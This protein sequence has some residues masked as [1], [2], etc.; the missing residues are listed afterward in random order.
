MTGLC[1][2]KNKAKHNLSASPTHHPQ[3]REAEPF[4]E[5]RN[6][7]HPLSFEVPLHKGN[8][9][10]WKLAEKQTRIFRVGCNLRSSQVLASTCQWALSE[11][12]GAVPEPFQRGPKRKRRETYSPFLVLAKAS[13]LMFRACGISPSVL[14]ICSR[15]KI[16][17]FFESCPT[18]SYAHWST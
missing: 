9:M 12:N 14:W 17:A 2:K 1:Y 13:W 16:K 7:I 11:T 5:V 8:T 6:V 10:I 4:I 15:N 3:H 18:D